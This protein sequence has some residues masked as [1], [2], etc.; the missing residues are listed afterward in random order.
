[1]Q[2]KCQKKKAKKTFKFWFNVMLGTE[3]MND[4]EH[5]QEFLTALQV[6]KKKSKKEVA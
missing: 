2:N 5:R 3:L 1:M 4:P 6:F